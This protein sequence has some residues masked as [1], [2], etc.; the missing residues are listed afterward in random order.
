M[1][2]LV[3]Y[4]GSHDAQQAALFVARIAAPLHAEVTLLGVTTRDGDSSLL[5]RRLEDLSARLST[6][7]PEPHIRLTTGHIASQILREVESGD[8]DLLA[9]G[10]RGHS[11]LSRFLL[12][13]TSLQLVRRAPIPVIVTRRNPAELRR[14]LVCTGGG[15]PHGV[16]SLALVVEMAVA[17]GAS[18]E[19]LHV[20]SQLPLTADAVGG[21]GLHRTAAWHVSNETDEGRHLAEVIEL[22]TAGGVTAEAKVRYGL[23]VDEIVDA[24]KSQPADLVVVGA[25]GQHG[26]LQFLL[27][28]I[29]ERV[30]DRLDRPVLVVRAPPA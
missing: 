30:I 28:D 25:H 27:D 17:T 4:D 12:G 13:A 15:P 21:A 9:L 5:R 6:T 2:V 29:T 23:V 20:M 8:Y 16:E 26:I 18:V 1:R 10:V 11:A 24:A 14:I 3:A 22:F 19:V 7:S